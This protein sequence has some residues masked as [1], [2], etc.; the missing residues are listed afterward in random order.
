[1]L[2][3]LNALLWIRDLEGGVTGPAIC[4]QSRLVWTTQL[5][6]TILHELLESLF[7]IDQKL[8]L[9]SI[10]S[11]GKIHELYH[12][13]RSFR[14]GS[15]SRALAKDLP[16]TNADFVNR[17]TQKEKAKGKKIA[18]KTMKGY[19]AQLDILLNCFLWYTHAM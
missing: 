1:V 11:L 18:H 19:Y 6:N 17:W 7:I 15:D 14:R 9:K 8:F 10:D 5:A 4:D 16:E 3:P 2:L 12:V 13:F